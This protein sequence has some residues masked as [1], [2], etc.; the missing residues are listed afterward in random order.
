MEKKN[1]IP[2]IGDIRKIAENH[3]ARYGN[4]LTFG[5]ALTYYYRNAGEDTDNISSARP[6]DFL[7]DDDF[8]KYIDNCFVFQADR[9]ISSG[10]SD[11][12]RGRK[13]LRHSVSGKMML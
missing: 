8:L 5:Q 2:R 7:S 13:S 12:G 11:G 1:R 4:K 6:D 9:I 10:F 3:F